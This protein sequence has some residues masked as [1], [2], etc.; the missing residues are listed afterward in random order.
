MPSFSHSW[1]PFLYLYGFGGFF[2]LSGMYIIHKAKALS[3][4]RKS[5]RKWRRVLFFGLFYFM[6]IHTILIIAAIYW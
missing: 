6:L 2:F 4:D 5:H 3:S 1:L